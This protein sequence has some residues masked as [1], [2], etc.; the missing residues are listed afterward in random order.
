MTALHQFWKKAWGILVLI[1]RTRNDFFPGIKAPGFDNN[2]LVC[3]HT[4]W[5]DVSE[6]LATDDILV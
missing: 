5:R 2:F 1:W 4:K 6:R 3:K